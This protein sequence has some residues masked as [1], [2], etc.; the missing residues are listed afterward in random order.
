VKIA[1]VQG[2]SAVSRYSVPDGFAI[3]ASVALR[4][5]IA[6]A[7]A[8]AVSQPA[9]PQLHDPATHAR[10]IAWP[11]GLVGVPVALR[12]L[13]RNRSYPW[14]VDAALALPFAL[15]SV[16]N[17]LDWYHEWVSYDTL[18][19]GVTWC[20]LALLIAMVP[21][22]RRLPAWVRFA[23]AIGAGAIGAIVWELGEFAAFIHD[24]PYK[25][26]AYPDTLADLFAGLIGATLGAFIAFFAL[27]DR[28]SGEQ[29][30]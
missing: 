11:I 3:A 4:A 10:E 6:A 18:N 27:D 20:V 5:I 21:A 1:D 29:P 14:L 16:G 22:V 26:T 9:L 15:D 28:R 30:Q 24:S 7:F 8:Y 19:H 25:R 2:I 12:L 23:V 17:V 13:S